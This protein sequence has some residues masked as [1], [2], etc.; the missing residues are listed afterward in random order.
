MRLF[1]DGGWA[2][3]PPIGGSAHARLANTLAHV[4]LTLASLT[5]L[6]ELELLLLP[7]QLPLG[8][9]HL[10]LG[11]LALEFPGFF[12]VLRDCHHGVANRGAGTSTIA[13][14]AA[15]L[16]AVAINFILVGPVQLITR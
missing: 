13:G 8:E 4:T 6:T 1:F 11:E 14:L 7:L 2:R 3:R 16:R 5:R 10:V 15:A 9:V 12:P